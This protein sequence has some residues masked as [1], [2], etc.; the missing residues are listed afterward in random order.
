[1]GIEFEQEKPIGKYVADFAIVDL[2][3][4]IEA[5]GIYW[6]DADRDSKRDS[7]L[8]ELGWTTFRLK[9][10][11]VNAATDVMNLLLSKLES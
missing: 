1:M 7:A 4:L 6:H 8:E 11:E 10:E 9:E 2:N 5:D 3:I